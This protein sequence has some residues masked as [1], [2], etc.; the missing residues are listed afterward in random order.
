MGCPVRV[1][2]VVVHGVPKSGTDRRYSLQALTKLE[3]A[4][5]KHK[6]PY[7]KV[8]L[9]S[10]LKSVKCVFIFIKGDYAFR[11]VR[12]PCPYAPTAFFM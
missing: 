8:L 1:K 10:Y 5:F 3:L 7:Q 11:F 12:N 4:V 6:R 9:K 2:Y